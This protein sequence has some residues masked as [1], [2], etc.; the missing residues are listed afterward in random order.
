MA[1]ISP[2][3]SIGR[4]VKNLVDEIGAVTVFL[5]RSSLMIFRPKQLAKIIQQIYY[6]GAGSI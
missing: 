1:I 2:F 5:A 4:S 3:D 6:I